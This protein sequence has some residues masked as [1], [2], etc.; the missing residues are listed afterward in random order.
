M[1]PSTCTPSRDL[2][3][4]IDRK[5]HNN[6]AGMT[7]GLTQISRERIEALAAHVPG[8]AKNDF[9]SS[10]TLLARCRSSN[11]SIHDICQRMAPDAWAAA[12]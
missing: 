12:R 6:L 1:G 3:G 8:A 11:S 2:K 5:R 7:Y 9:Y 4:A 10:R